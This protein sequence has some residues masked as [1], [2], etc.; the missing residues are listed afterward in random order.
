[1]GFHIGVSE[2]TVFPEHGAASQGNPVPTLRGTVLSL[3]SRKTWYFGGC[4]WRQWQIPQ[5]RNAA[6]PNSY[7]IKSYDH[8]PI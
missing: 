5:E 6:L 3:Y 7:P 1:M 4:G 8:I 2:S